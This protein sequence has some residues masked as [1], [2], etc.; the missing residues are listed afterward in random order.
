[1]E[2]QNGLGMPMTAVNVDKEIIDFETFPLSQLQTAEIV[3]LN[4]GDNPLIVPNIISSCNC[5]KVEYDKQPVEPGEKL[6]LKVSYH[7]DRKGSFRKI[8]NIYC[9]VKRSP[10]QVKIYGRAE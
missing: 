5:V 9:N 6:S 8:L 4:L 2:S 1:M 7:S 10:L 3:L